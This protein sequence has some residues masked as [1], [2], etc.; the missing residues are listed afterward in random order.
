MFYIP[1]VSSKKNQPEKEESDREGQSGEEEE[2]SDE[3]VVCVG[4][5]GSLYNYY[6]KVFCFEILNN[7]CQANKCLVL[8]SLENW[9]HFF[10]LDF[11][12]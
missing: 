4:A 9:N 1:Y 5:K 2:E 7:K 11:P 12:G 3:R 10:L 8:K 6:E